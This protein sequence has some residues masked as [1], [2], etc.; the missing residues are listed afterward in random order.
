MGKEG[1]H[2]LPSSPP[3]TLKNGRAA[4]AHPPQQLLGRAAVTDCGGKI[5]KSKHKVLGTVGISFTKIWGQGLGRFWKGLGKV[6]EGFGK[7]WGL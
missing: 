1:C 4:A 7:I 3:A 6:L 2:P 5:L